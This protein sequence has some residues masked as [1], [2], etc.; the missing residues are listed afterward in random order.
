MLVGDNVQRKGEAKVGVV[1]SM[2]VRGVAGST[3]T[4]IDWIEVTYQ[5]GTVIK[6][7]PFSFSVVKKASDLESK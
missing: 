3:A 1:T 6:G 7:L 2:R 4:Y 5:N